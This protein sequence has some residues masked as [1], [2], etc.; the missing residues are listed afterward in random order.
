MDTR[1]NKSVST[2]TLVQLAELVLTS[3]IFEHNGEIFQQIQGTA[4]GTK[5]A[6]S[7][8]ILFMADFENKATQAFDSDLHVWYR[9]ID[10]TFFIW[11]SGEEK[12]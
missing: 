5:M 12:L 10:D 8:A 4:M 6:P 9:Y 2:D 11:K 1:E 7:Y 3:N